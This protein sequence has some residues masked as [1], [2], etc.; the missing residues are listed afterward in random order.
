MAASKHV[1][2]TLGME[3]PMD[4]DIDMKHDS[5]MAAQEVAM[6][7]EIQRL[8]QQSQSIKPPRLEF[9]FSTQQCSPGR[10]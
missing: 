2:A 4:F 8:E 1:E 10:W 6:D 7:E 5:A 3:D 9:A